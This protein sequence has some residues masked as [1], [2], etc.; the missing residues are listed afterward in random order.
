[1]RPS[2]KPLNEDRTTKD[3]SKVL[4]YRDFKAFTG[5]D[6]KVWDYFNHVR[7]SPRHEA[8]VRFTEDS[9]WGPQNP[10]NAAQEHVVRFGQEVRPDV[11]FLSGVDWR[12]IERADRPESPVPVINL[13]QHV[14]HASRDDRLGRHRFLPYKAIRICVSPEVTEALE[15]TGRVRGPIFTIPDA[16]DV[17]RLSRF[18]GDGPPSLDLLVVANKQPARGHAILARFPQVQRK[19]I[20]DV[21]SPHAEVMELIG[22]AA[23]TVFVP[24]PKEGFFLPALEGMA[25]GTIVVCPDCIGNRS[26]C[27]DGVNCFRPAYEENAIVEAAREALARRSE[28]SAMVENARDTA[29]RH[30]IEGER[31]AFLEILERVDEL[32]AAA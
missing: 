20:V 14:L 12:L 23:V 11:L 19:R 13:I 15:G 28:L 4:F 8:L 27:L 30:D 9:I 17:Q 22:R 29:R 3:K 21:R 24:N 10:W 18:T 2:S 16:I 32:W 31:R 1:L 26:F 6:L 5:G 25:I 7:S